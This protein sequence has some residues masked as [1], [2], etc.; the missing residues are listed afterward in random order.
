[1]ISTLTLL[2]GGLALILAAVGLYGVTAYT[3]EQ[4]T[5]EI[6]VR[7]ALGA[8][9]GRVIVMVLR[10][11]LWQVGIGLLPGIPAALGAGKLI[12]DQ[13]YGVKPGDPI[14]LAGATLCL[15]LA[16]VI[17]ALIPAQRAANLD[18]VEALRAE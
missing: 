6:G 3:V 2:F 17:A 14:M 7:M 11:A 5:S 15:A 16:A 4:R 10:G 12:T 1:M 9:R 13:L 8:D 18:P